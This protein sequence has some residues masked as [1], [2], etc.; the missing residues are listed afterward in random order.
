VQITYQSWE[1]DRTTV[2]CNSKQAMD[3]FGFEGLGPKQRQYVTPIKL[4]TLT[5]ETHIQNRFLG[6]P[7]LI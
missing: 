7:V 6:S 2:V 5:V 4:M 3:G 1:I